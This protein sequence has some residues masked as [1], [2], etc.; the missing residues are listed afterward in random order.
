MK[1]TDRQQQYLWLVGSY[2]DKIAVQGRG[3]RT[4]RLMYGIRDDELVIFG[5]SSPFYF[6][7]GRGLV[8]KLDNANAYVLTDDGE[9]AY[10]EMLVRGAG[11]KI[12][13][14]IKEVQVK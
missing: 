9:R 8:R 14:S 2:A 11:M 3:Y 13:R 6:L 12:N 1:L 10:R 5:Y 4:Q 7:E